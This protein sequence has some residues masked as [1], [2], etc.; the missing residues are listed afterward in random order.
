MEESKKWIT[1]DRYEQHTGSCW[2]SVLLYNLNT[3]QGSPWGWNKHNISAVRIC[4][5]S[6]L[7][8]ILL[9]PTL[10][11]NWQ[12]PRFIPVHSLTVFISMIGQGRASVMEPHKQRAGHSAVRIHNLIASWYQ[13]NEQTT[14]DLKSPVCSNPKTTISETYITLH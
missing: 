14:T 12:N 2:P 5:P 7:H 11:F 6:H 8:Q 1:R 3:D 9:L 10:S 13:A 4:Q